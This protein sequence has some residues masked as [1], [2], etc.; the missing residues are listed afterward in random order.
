MMKFFKS[1]PT[2]ECM[3]VVGVCGS[4]LHM[5]T[6][7]NLI[8]IHCDSNTEYPLGYSAIIEFSMD[9]LSW[10]KQEPCAMRKARTPNYYGGLYVANCTAKYLR[11]TNISVPDDFAVGYNI[12]YT[13]K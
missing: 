9:N 4:T 8:E 7:I 12:T 1:V 10:Y 2:T 5:P 11:I 6:N 3:S 13:R